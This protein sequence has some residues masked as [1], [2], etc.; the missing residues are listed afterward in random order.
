MIFTGKLGATLLSCVLFLCF[1]SAS[2]LAAMPVA[3]ELA[4][5]F[6]FTFH[7]SDEAS[8]LDKMLGEKATLLFFVQTACRPCLREIKAA[9]E[10]AEENSS[11]SV[12]SVFVDISPRTIKRYLKNNELILPT[13]W[14]EDESISKLYSITFTPTSFL[15]DNKRKIVKAYK[16]FHRGAERTLKNDVEEL[17]GR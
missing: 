2:A 7:A 10:L 3:G 4:P 8:T 9:R 6:A 1:F 11:F 16:G 15:L 14:D 13:T 5:D 12:L 17:L